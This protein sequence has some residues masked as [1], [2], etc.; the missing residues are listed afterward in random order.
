MLY[1]ALF[2][3]CIAVELSPKIH[4]ENILKKIAIGF[5]AVGAL[6]EFYGRNSV[7]IEVGILVYLVAN[8]ATAYCSN[9]KRRSVDR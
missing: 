5:I 1:L 4:T 3:A 6:V 9:P 7:F 8:L 2:G